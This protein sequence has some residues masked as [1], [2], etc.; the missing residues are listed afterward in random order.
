MVFFK[1]KFQ[2]WVNFG[3]YCNGRC[4]FY[5]HLVHFTVFWYILLTFGILCG[6]LVYFSRLVFCTKENL[7]T[8]YGTTK[9]I[10]LILFCACVVLY[11]IS[12]VH[13]LD[14]VNRPSRPQ[15]VQALQKMTSA[16]M[17]SRPSREQKI[18]GSKPARF[19]AKLSF[20]T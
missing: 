2:I 3:G 4:I 9:N 18:A 16:V 14:C 11:D 8:L 19:S 12:S 1:P 5:G 6:N 10:G 13:R 15:L 20:E 17:A 7:A